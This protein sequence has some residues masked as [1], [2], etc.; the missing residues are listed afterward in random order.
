MIPLVL[1]AV[2]AVRLGPVD[3]GAPARSPYVAANST[4]AAVAFGAGKAIYFSP[5]HDRAKTFSAPVKVAEASV[6]PLSRHRGPRVAFSGKVIVVT[7]RPSG[8]QR[9]ED[10]ARFDRRQNDRPATVGGAGR[11]TLASRSRG[12]RT[13]AERAGRARTPA[14]TR[15]TAGPDR[16]AGRPHGKARPVFVGPVG[17]PAG[18]DPP[19]LRSARNRNRSGAASSQEM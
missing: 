3:L 10:A 8:R 15:S 16:A 1:G 19:S 4:T 13:H 18:G 11:Q 2:L 5:S 9:A 7:E 6:L 12:T 14:I 17:E